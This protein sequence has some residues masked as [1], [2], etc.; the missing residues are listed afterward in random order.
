MQE[1]VYCELIASLKLPSAYLFYRF[2]PW[3]THYTAIPSHRPTVNQ[4]AAQ[5]LTRRRAQIAHHG[6]L[7]EIRTRRMP[8]LITRENTV[9]YEKGCQLQG[10]AA[11]LFRFPVPTTTKMNRLHSSTLPANVF[12]RR[13]PP[14]VVDL[15]R[16]LTLR[17]YSANGPAP[18]VPHMSQNAKSGTGW[19]GVA[20]LLLS[21]SIVSAGIGYS[22]ASRYPRNDFLNV[23]DS[24]KFGSPKDFEN[25]IA[26]L[27]LTFTSDKS[28]ST[29]PVDLHSHGFSDNDYHP[30]A[31][32]SPS[33]LARV[34]KVRTRRTS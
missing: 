18:R 9:Y 5:K 10:E 11:T 14:R 20:A 27:R 1:S 31:F 28:V 4:S 15:S 19:L 16:E 29:D 34:L 8:G 21:A 32:C 33:H 22:A 25:A 23:P 17:R 13:W 12:R 2:T 7:R 3:Y 24:P 30:G 6:T 26:E